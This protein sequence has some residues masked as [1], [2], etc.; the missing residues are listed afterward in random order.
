MAFHSIS[1]GLIENPHR[2][3]KS[4]LFAHL[5][6]K[7]TEVLLGLRPS[8]CENLRATTAELL[9]GISLRLPGEFFT[10]TKTDVNAAVLMQNLKSSMEQPIPT[11]TILN[12][13]C[14]SQRL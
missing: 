8:Y 10:R 13:G 4:T 1:N 12:E 9:N 11:P 7:W 6:D 2:P 3:L 5:T 14:L